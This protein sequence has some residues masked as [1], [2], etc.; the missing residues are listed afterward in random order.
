MPELSVSVESLSDDE[1]P[2]VR[3]EVAGSNSKRPCLIRSD[4]STYRGR[5]KHMTSLNLAKIIEDIDGSSSVEWK[6]QRQPM[7]RKASSMPTERVT[8][9]IA[10]L[11]KSTEEGSEPM[12]ARSTH[13]IVRGFSPSRISSSYR[14]A[15][16]VAASPAPSALKPIAPA[17]APAQAPAQKKRRKMFIVGSSSGS[18]DDDDDD[19]SYRAPARHSNNGKKTSFQEEVA[20][21]TLSNNG[22]DSEDEQVFDDEEEEEEGCWESSSDSG[23]SSED[24]GALFK[25]VESRPEL[26][27]SRRSLLST[28]LHEPERAAQLA[29]AASRSTP[30]LRRHNP[31][32]ELQPTVNAVNAVNAKEKSEFPGSQ[33]IRRN[34]SAHPLA[35]SPRTTRRNM[36][37]TELTESLRK[38]LL[39]ERQQKNGTAMKRRHTALDM[40]KLV[41]YPQPRVQDQASKTNSW[42]NPF[43][44][45]HEY[46]A[47]G[48]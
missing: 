18:D 21:R 4:S 36:L 22:G 12:S 48:W 31:P 25:R 7:Q 13:S 47:V 9:A 8:A 39:W 11:T 1:L 17:P 28:M 19:H 23:D 20:T 46:H 42:S 27:T 14:S 35:F 16:N 29:N 34:N 41:D 26:L 45:I 24:D 2:K 15:V 40:T 33:P 37:A 5:E 38:H 43:E 6:A 44:E 32:K 30:A 10:A 3:S